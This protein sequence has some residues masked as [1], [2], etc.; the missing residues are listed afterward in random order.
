[1]D[2]VWRGRLQ[3]T[4][5][6]RRTYLQGLLTNDIAQLPAG[7]GCYAAMLNAQGRMLTDMHVFE[8]GDRVLM[9]LPAVVTSSIREHLD[10]FIFAE[11]VHVEDVSQSCAQIGVYG[12]RAGE[13]LTRA[14]LD[15][16]GAAVVSSDEVGID[17][18]DVFVDRTSA[19]VVR[20]ALVRSGAIPATEVDVET[21]RIERGR[22]RWGADMDTDTI[23]LEAGIE[24]RA[25]S[26]TKG[27]YVGQEVI[28]R[29]LDR[30][31]GRVA[32][33]LVGLSFDPSAA[34]PASGAPITAGGRET[35]RVTSA[36]WSPALERPIALGYVHR[37]FVDPGTPVEIAGA[38]A[39]VANLPFRR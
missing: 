5:A 37:D 33:R 20:D 31:H 13:A 28:V 1:M 27:C 15:V 4:G 19:A 34:V 10:R 35:G 36:V 21:V 32:R 23:P 6:D 18:F 39:T 9:T 17:G 2:P 25:I 7:S 8:L 30:G 26:R 38:K 11:E 16:P 14:A 12:P 22:A 24:D 3:L 29:V